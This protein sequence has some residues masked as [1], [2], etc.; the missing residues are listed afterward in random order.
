[1]ILLFTLPEGCRPAGTVNTAAD[2]R[3]GGV[4][5]IRPDGTVWCNPTWELVER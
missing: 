3:L 2:L 1:M 5:V 4:V